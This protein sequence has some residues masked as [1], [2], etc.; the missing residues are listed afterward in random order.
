MIITR[1]ADVMAVAGLLLHR[2]LYGLNALGKA[3]KE[4]KRLDGNR[5][6]DCIYCYETGQQDL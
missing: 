1:H 5:A 6:E 3:P 2:Q 4:Q